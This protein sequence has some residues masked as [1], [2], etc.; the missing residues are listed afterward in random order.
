MTTAT[1]NKI[2]SQLADLQSEI[3]Y[4]KSQIAIFQ[5]KLSDLEHLKAHQKRIAY[6]NVLTQLFRVQCQLIDLR[7]A[8]EK[9]L[10]VYD[11]LLDKR[12][13]L[14]KQ[15]ADLDKQFLDKQFVN[16]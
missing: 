3:D 16:S 13:E 8:D 12:A 5:A 9:W 1:I 10:L 6:H 2:D 11:V 7:K 15:L 4:L 14:D